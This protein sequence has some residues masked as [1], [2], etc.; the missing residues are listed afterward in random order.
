M[1][2]SNESNWDN[3]FEA[4]CTEVLGQFF[5]QMFHFSN[6]LLSDNETAWIVDSATCA[7]VTRAGWKYDGISMRNEVLL[8]CNAL[9]NVYV[10]VSLLRVADSF[11]RKRF[12]DS[13]LLLFLSFTLFLRR[14]FFLSA[15]MW[16][17]TLWLVGYFWACI[18]ND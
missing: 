10:P 18:R 17:F 1:Y 2:L 8:L 6:L 4:W 7:R 5:W 9:G 13:L 15:V 12:E 11:V 16:I 14:V 3:F